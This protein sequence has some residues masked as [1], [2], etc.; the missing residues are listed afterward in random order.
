MIAIGPHTCFPMWRGRGLSDLTVSRALWC[1]VGRE[2]GFPG[3][4]GEGF[5]LEGLSWP[6]EG[7][8]EGEGLSSLRAEFTHVAH[9]TPQHT[10]HHHGPRPQPCPRAP[11]SAAPLP[12]PGPDDSARYNSVVAGPEPAPP[13]GR[14]GR[15]SWA[16]DRGRCSTLINTLSPAPRP[17]VGPRLAEGPGWGPRLAEGPMAGRGWPKASRLCPHRAA[18]VAWPVSAPAIVP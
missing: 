8:F 14:G 15:G 6:F 16:G 4:C 3:L 5:P 12:S 10:H 17:V 13:V 18:I 1:V 11:V 9:S 2:K 7:A